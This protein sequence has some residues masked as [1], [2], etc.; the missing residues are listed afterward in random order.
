MKKRITALGYRILLMVIVAAAWSTN[1]ESQVIQPFAKKQLT[2]K[3]RILFKKLSSCSNEAVWGMVLQN[4][5]TNIFTN[6]LKM[7]LHPELRMVGRARTVRVV[8]YRKDL[9]KTSPIS[10]KLGGDNVI[11]YTFQAAED[12]EAGDILVIDAGGIVD[13]GNLGDQMYYRFLAQ[14]CGG[15]VI[16]GAIRDMQEISEA[17]SPGYMLDAH[18]MHA[19]PIM[20]VDYQ[21][22]VNIGGAVVAPGDILLGDMEGIV[23]VPGEIAESIADKA[24][25]HSLEEEFYRELLK[26][27]R[28]LIGL[29]PPD[30][31][32]QKLWEAYKKEHPPEF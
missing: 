25:E 20:T 15:L 28:S 11:F 27:G 9:L 29:H 30:E 18:A 14:G 21:V 8:P 31:E 24:Y 3:D 1:V 4:G 23:V 22:P 19:A 12:T 32:V 17:N 2:Q 26:Q 5:Y 7:V 13:A 16:N 6:K 10:G